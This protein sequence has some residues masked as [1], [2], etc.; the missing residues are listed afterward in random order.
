HFVWQ[1]IGLALILL[2]LVKLGN[3]RSARYR[4][5]LSVGI[6]AMMGIA[7]VMTPIWY[8]TLH[9]SRDP[10]PTA[11]SATFD[12]VTS[13]DASVGTTRAL[14]VVIPAKH[15]Q[16]N[17]AS[18]VG[19]EVYVLIAWMTGVCILSLRL[20]IGFGIGLWIRAKA[21]PLSAEFER[22]VQAL[23]ERLA[24]NVQSRVFA[25]AR[26][27]QA[28]AIGFLRPVVLIPTSWLT[29]LAP[30]TI[31]AIIAH[32]LAHIRRWDLWV[33]LV[34]RVIETLLFYHP[35]VWW[36]SDRI[37]LERE[38][39]CDE[40][41]ATC[42]DRATYARSLASVA[43][44]SNH[45][46]LLATSIGGGRKMK[47]LNRIGYLLG[48]APA[49]T[50]GNWWTF[51]LVAV[52]LPF[53]AI[54]S[55]CYSVAAKPPA[56]K[57][58]ESARSKAVDAVV[59]ARIQPKTVT[60]I[61]QYVGTI[62]SHRHI[63]IR[64]LEKGYID[65]LSV[66]EGQRV[67]AG[68]S[69]FNLRPVMSQARL[70]AELADAKIAQLEYNNAKRLHDQK[71]VSADELALHEA[72]LAKAMAKVK[73][74]EAELQF[75]TAKAPFDGIIERL[76]RQQGSSVLEG[77]T[78]T[79]LS[80]NTTVRVYF[81]IPEARYLEYIADSQQKED[82]QVQLILADRTTFDQPG[83]VAS[84]EADFNSE[85]GTIGFCADFPNPS[86]ILRHGQRA[87]VL[88]NRQRKNAIVVPQR[89]TFEILGKR[90]VYSV[91]KDQ[92]AHLREITVRQELNDTFII[93]TGLSGDEQIVI[94]GLRQ[95]VDGGKVPGEENVN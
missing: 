56:E 40:I 86:G 14:D 39:C 36:L 73:I 49:N 42:F 63:Q 53:A 91:D 71:V 68:D 94:E 69:I 28:V 31:E 15:P 84:I 47:L 7:P 21:Q 37:R 93:K 19:V 75:A 55:F 83:R 77:D 58:K 2:I 74:A 4:Y 9:S 60:L 80:D 12:A 57:G 5:L 66:K 6:L 95:I 85:T 62:N 25:C 1:G 43:T 87:I 79:T 65:E 17:Q 44:I 18:Q 90:F 64:A 45:N 3:V 67:K 48:I 78:V 92:I 24:V 26:V 35:A 13:E 51:G 30:Q 46:L 88:V 22:R 10:A 16:T 82:L 50:A 33:N 54:A 27:G 32:E 41:A 8:Q 81:E 59:T 38:M 20:A 76:E 52:V 89:A 61:E 34:Q 11:V 70:D 72:K 29:Q 23:G